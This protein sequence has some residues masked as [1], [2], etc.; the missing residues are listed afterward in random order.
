LFLIKAYM[1]YYSWC[2]SFP[3][4]GSGLF[5]NWNKD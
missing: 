4:C 1:H 5:S 2:I 3:C